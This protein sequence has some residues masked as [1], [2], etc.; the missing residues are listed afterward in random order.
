MKKTSGA[1]DKVFKWIIVTVKA[2]LKVCR[3]Y[4]EA[5]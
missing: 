5:E 4:R 3:V 2:T 1:Q